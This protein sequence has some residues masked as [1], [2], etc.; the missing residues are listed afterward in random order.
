MDYEQFKLQC[1][2]QHGALT[3]YPQELVGLRSRRHDEQK[4]MNL[5]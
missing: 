3:L 1:Y 2:A 5:G 4:N